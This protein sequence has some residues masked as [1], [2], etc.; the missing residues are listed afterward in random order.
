[1]CLGHRMAGGVSFRLKE[2]ECDITAKRQVKGVR[3]SLQG[4]LD[5]QEKGNITGQTG[6]RAF[7]EENNTFARPS[8]VLGRRQVARWILLFGRR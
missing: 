3:K 1:M 5:T 8:L 6:A 2:V 4:W 7:L